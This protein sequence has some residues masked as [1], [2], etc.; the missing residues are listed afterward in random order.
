MIPNYFL[1]LTLTTSSTS[2]LVNQFQPNT[3]H[4]LFESLYL[5]IVIVAIVIAITLIV[6]RFNLHKF[7]DF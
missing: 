6:Q 7:L 3:F 5:E 4:I 2:L 1:N